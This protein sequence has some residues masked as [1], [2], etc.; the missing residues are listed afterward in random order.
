MNIPFAFPIG[1]INP[2]TPAAPANGPVS[3]STMPTMVQVVSTRRMAAATV[4]LS[5]VAP[6]EAEG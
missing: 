4:V 3:C 6:A 2:E 5:A 1:I